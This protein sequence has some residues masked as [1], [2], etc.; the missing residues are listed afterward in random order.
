[1]DIVM[2][3]I[4]YVS[5]EA[6][7]IPRNYTVSEVEGDL[8]IEDRY[9]DGL[10]EIKAG[11]KIYLLFYFHKSPAFSE[12]FL[13]IK[14]P[15]HDRKV[16]VFFTHSPFR[17]NPIGM[18]VLKVIGVNGTSIRVRGIDMLDQTP[19]L[20]IKPVSTPWESQ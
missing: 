19:I 2:K 5:H 6:K 9:K 13:R 12:Q 14:P 3:P 18:S 8:I 7:E 10:R 1:M 4:G 20:D 16:G 11:Q 15:I 17:P